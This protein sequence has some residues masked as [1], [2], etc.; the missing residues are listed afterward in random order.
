MTAAKPTS[1]SELKQFIVTTGLR[2]PEQ[3][4]RVARLAAVRSLSFTASLSPARRHSFP[5]DARSISSSHSSAVL[6]CVRGNRSGSKTSIRSVSIT[7]NSRMRTILKSLFG[8]RS[9]KKSAA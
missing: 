9:S 6:M 1:L 8:R 7:T 4:E 3:Q 2:L 5:P